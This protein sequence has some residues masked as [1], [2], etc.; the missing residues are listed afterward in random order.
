MGFVPAGMGKRQGWARCC[1]SW[2]NAYGVRPFH[3][4]IFCLV[5][6]YSR[7]QALERAAGASVPDVHSA[8]RGKALNNSCPLDRLPTVSAGLHLIRN[9]R[10]P[11]ISPVLPIRISLFATAESA[12]S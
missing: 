2:G 3:C 9:S 10:A 7:G 8:S 1:V 4:S 11:S 6:E 5:I 12:D